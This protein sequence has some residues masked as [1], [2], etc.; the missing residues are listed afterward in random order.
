MAVTAET[1]NSKFDQFRFVDQT[2][3]TELPRLAFSVPEMVID[4]E[5]RHKAARF[6][7]AVA[8]GHCI[9]TTTYI[10]PLESLHEA[11][12]AAAEGNEQAMKLIETNVKTDV[13]ERTIKSGHVMSVDLMV[14][15]A[16]KI[17]QHGQ[18]LDSVQAN[19]LRY[20]AN[21]RQMRERT[22]AETRNAFRIEELYKNGMLQ[23]YSFVVFSRAADNMN[24]AEMDKVGFFTET[25][26]CAIQVTFAKEDRLVTESAFVSGIKESGGSRHDGRAIIELAKRLDVDLTGMNAT[27]I[28]DTPLLIHNSLLPNRAIDLVSMYDECA[29]GT[30]F[31]EDKPIQDYSDYK[32]LCLER[33]QRF[34][35]KVKKIVDQL[36][37]EA[38][39]IHNPVMAVERLHKIAEAHMIEQAVG[40]DDINPRVFG[41]MAANFITQARMAYI[42]NQA[43]HLLQNLKFAKQHATSSSCPGVASNV[44]EIIDDGEQDSEASDDCEFVSKECP[45]CHAKNVRTKVTKER[46]SGDCGCSVAKK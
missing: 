10:N 38:G 30:F 11:V 1:W 4:E 22:E 45:V 39:S 40:D 37:G 23:D 3:L 28:I 41:V 29:G 14:D 35:P 7:G 46:I 16:G 20:A 21:S 27:Q 34:A 44:E 17:R 15:E 26:S 36:I 19:S 33:E 5:V 9:E 13:V 43:D 18:S 25:M 31:G 42:N 8:T 2:T 12:Q 24:V 6:I 32:A